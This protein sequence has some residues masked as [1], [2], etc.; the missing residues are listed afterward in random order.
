MTI[1]QEQNQTD[2]TPGDQHIL[3]LLNASMDG[4]ISAAEQAELD[5]LLAN[6]ES[7]RN[8]DKQLKTIAKLLDE[9]PVLEPPQHLKSSIER[10]VRLPADGGKR[11]QPGA[12]GQWL[13]SQ[14]LRTGLALAAGV[15]LTFSVYEMGSRPISNRDTENLSGTMVKKGLTSQQGTLLD[16]VHLDTAQ[17]S[18]L[19]E[20]RNM[21]DV[22]TLDVQLNSEDPVDVVVDIAGR[23]LVFDGATHAQDSNDF[24]SV[25]DGAIHLASSGENRF[26]VKLRRTS[27]LQQIEPIELDFFAKNQLVK[28]AELNISRF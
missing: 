21:D 2:P 16:R 10:Q 8:L 28:K 19:V 4:E 15:V 14:W 1:M 6:S 9:L 27:D 17:F 5:L 12:L 25:R 7:V 22:F 20:L 13:D 26:T 18:G 24:V 11:K 3:D 23:G